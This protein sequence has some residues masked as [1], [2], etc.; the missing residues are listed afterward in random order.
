VKDVIC[1]ID[2]RPCEMD[3]PDRYLE[4]PGGGCALTTAQELG[5][6]IIDFGGG[7]I[8]MLFVPKQ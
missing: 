7:D 4:Q 3:C 6:K 2:G 8:G 1:P 5:A